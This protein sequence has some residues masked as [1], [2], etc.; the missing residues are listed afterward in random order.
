MAKRIF[1]K[2]L[3]I[4]LAPLVFVSCETAM[5]ERSRID[6][7]AEFRKQI[8]IFSMEISD[9]IREFDLDQKNIGVSTFVEL[10][11]LEKSS[12][13]GRYVPEQVS[14]EL[15]KLNFHIRDLR[16]RI[17]VKTAPMLGEFALSRQ[18]REIMKKF[19]IDAILTGVY[20]IVGHKLVVNARILNVDTSR[21]VS[22]GRMVIDLDRNIYVHNL[23]NRN[24][25][26]PEQIVKVYAYDDEGGS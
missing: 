2:W 12:S 10:D 9:R 6:L 17:N 22:V 26:G 4:A 20:M 8:E 19:R 14:S 3:I 5:R 24:T 7:E 11:N 16:Q 15:Y 21:L 25:V 18:S 1:S 23:L 13:F